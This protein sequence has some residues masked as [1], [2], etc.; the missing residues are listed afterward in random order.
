MAWE[1]K[2]WRSVAKLDWNEA[3]SETTEGVK[4]ALI[5]FIKNGRINWYPDTDN[6]KLR[7]ALS[8]YCSV[9]V[10]NVQYFNSSDALHENIID[11]FC[12]EGQPSLIVTPT[13]DQFRSLSESRGL[14]TNQFKL[15]HEYEIDFASLEK[16]IEQLKPKIIYICNPNN[17]TGTLHDRQRLVELIQNNNNVLFLIDEAYF[18]FGGYTLA[19]KVDTLDNL[20]ISRTFSKAF[21]LASLRIGYAISCEENISALNK[22][23][24]PKH[25]SAMAQVAALAALED[26]SG[27]EHYAKEVQELKLKV[28]ALLTDLNIEFVLGG[29]NFF[30]LKMDEKMKKE[31]MKQAQKNNIFIRNL[32]HLPDFKKYCRITLGNNSQI[33]KVIDILKEII[34]KNE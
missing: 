9:D 18:E 8:R 19:D 7:Q 4:T 26:L 11:T 25:T 27:M 24:N 5:E 17:P 29:G 2:D 22:V 34:Q 1:E 3:S 6:A 33:T 15:T 14:T 23:R 16:E 30:L 10:S 31:F 28:P 20:V 12:V 32:S 21:G 13:Y